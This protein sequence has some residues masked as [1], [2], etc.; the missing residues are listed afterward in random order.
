MKVQFGFK[1]F[2]K[3]NL[4]TVV[5][6]GVFDGV[7]LGHRKILNFIVK[8]A[9]KISGISLVVTFW[10]HPK[11]K[12]H[13]YSLSHRLKLIEELG[14]N[15]ALVVRFNHFFSRIQPETFIEKILYEKIHASYV[16]IGKNF[17]FGREAR[18]DEKLLEKLSSEYKYKLKV[19][20]VI[21]FNGT[22]VSSSYIRRLIKK[23]KLKE[24]EKLLVHPVSVLGTV[25]KGRSLAR[26][27]GF[28]TANIDPHH[29]VLPPPGVYAVSIV[30]KKKR[31][32]GICYIGPKPKFLEAKDNQGYYHVEVHIF[33]FKRNIY[34][35][36]LEINFIKKIRDPRNFTSPET[37]AAKVK[38]DILCAKKLFFFH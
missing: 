17:R 6:L 14:V 13:L 19:F 34:H 33:N 25:I 4:P 5:A 18:G 24:A 10:P 36:N 8:R 12:P 11:K 15:A 38:N 7:H 1:N 21:K 23:G 28:P 32:Y 3:I 35:Q 22:A 16:C 2:R 20:K 9:K 31:Y 30:L 27:L 37:L 29:E 26:K